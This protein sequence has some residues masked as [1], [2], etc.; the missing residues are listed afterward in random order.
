MGFKKGGLLERIAQA[1]TTEG[2]CKSCG[3]LAKVSETAL[4]CTAHD[5]L[6]IPKFLPYHGNCKCKDWKQ[7]EEQQ[8]GRG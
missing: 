2:I 7:R 5:K 3:N 4:G 6:I 1:N 8:N